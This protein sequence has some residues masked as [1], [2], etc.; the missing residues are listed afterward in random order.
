MA[1]TSPF[2]TLT[3]QMLE[4]QFGR[5]IL[6]NQTLYERR[7][8]RNDFWANSIKDQP[9]LMRISGPN[10][11]DDLRP[12]GWG[13]NGTA[14]HQPGE[15]P[16]GGL[17]GLR[18]G[19]PNDTSTFEDMD[20]EPLFGD[21]GADP[22]NNPGDHHGGD[23]YA[24]LS[25]AW[26]LHDRPD[27]CKMIT[28]DPPGSHDDTSRVCEDISGCTWRWEDPDDH[29]KGGKC[30][31]TIPVKKKNV[32]NKGF[33][34]DDEPQKDFNPANPDFGY[35]VA[36]KPLSED[37][38]VYHPMAGLMSMYDWVE[39]NCDKDIYAFPACKAAN[40]YR[41]QGYGSTPTGDSYENY[42]RPR[43]KRK[44]GCYECEEEYFVCH[45]TGLYHTRSRG[46]RYLGRRRV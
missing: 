2:S 34:W 31:D 37:W 39:P 14:G 8:Y 21:G 15:G 17:S 7:D 23:G 38:G 32:P 43:L 33:F 25:P 9:H 26:G 36:S 24:D 5:D 29:D 20:R 41:G 46:C 18:G 3:N 45:D 19:D 42:T 40:T 27:Y 12:G 44:S 11:V 30:G 16:E 10:G 22:V 35:P 6:G 13:K 1:P 4:D 28:I